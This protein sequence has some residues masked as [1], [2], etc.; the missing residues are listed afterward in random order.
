VK[1][2]CLTAGDFLLFHIYQRALNIAPPLSRVNFALVNLSSSCPSS[3]I[4]VADI[5]QILF[6]SAASANALRE[7]FFRKLKSDLHMIRILVNVLVDW[8]MIDPFVK[9]PLLCDC[10]DPAVT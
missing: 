5:R 10:W 7:V 9:W 6:D 3:W 1:R 2:L 8:I 4:H